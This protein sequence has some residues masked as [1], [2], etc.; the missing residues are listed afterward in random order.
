M[1]RRHFVYRYFYEHDIPVDFV[2]SE[3]DFS[4]YDLLIDPMHFLMS[5]SY[6]EKIDNYVKNGGK[7]VGTYI[8]GVVDEN[9]LAYMNEWPK[10]LQKIYGLEPLET[11]VLYPGQSNLINFEG[12]EY[13]VHDYCETLINCT[14]KVLATY[15][16]EFLSRYTCYC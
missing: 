9:D 7:I 3:D 1:C 16:T 2:S 10:E 11:D 8:S 15:S 14:G 12:K 4:Q 13:P 6:L 5:K